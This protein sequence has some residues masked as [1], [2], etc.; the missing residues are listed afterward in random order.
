MASPAIV[1]VEVAAVDGCGVQRVEIG[2]ADVIDTTPPTIDVELDRD[3]LWPSN[4][5][6][7]DITAQVTVEDNCPIASFGL[8]S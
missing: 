6:M 5:R 4:H 8:V 7:V 1:R 3:T 2:D